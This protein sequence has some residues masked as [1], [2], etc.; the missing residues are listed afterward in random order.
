V[1]VDAHTVRTHL[2]G[3]KGLALAARRAVEELTDDIADD[4]QASD[5]QEELQE[6]ATDLEMLV[7]QAEALEGVVTGGDHP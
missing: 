6:I 3:I 1:D 4:E 5:I 2:N 7:E